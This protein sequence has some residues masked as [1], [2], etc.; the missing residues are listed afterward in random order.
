MFLYYAK[1]ESDDVIGDSTETAE[2]S[3][4]NTGNSRNIEAVGLQT[5]HQ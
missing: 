5:W 1:E 4:K 3:I 2:H